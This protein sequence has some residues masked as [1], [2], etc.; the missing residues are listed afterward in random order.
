MRAA[1]C[2]GVSGFAMA[3]VDVAGAASALLAITPM[4]HPIGP[5]SARSAGNLLDVCNV[6]A[7]ADTPRM[8]HPTACI[9]SPILDQTAAFCAEASYTQGNVECKLD[10]SMSASL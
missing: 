3:D 9:G 4:I 2:A 8:T 5:P 10:H 7:K 6:S 1:I